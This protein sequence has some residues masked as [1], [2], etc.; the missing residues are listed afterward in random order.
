M[1]LALQTQG[2]SRRFPGGQ[3]VHALDLAVPA[4]A[5]YGFL[6]PNGAG[7]TTTIRLLLG[8][9]RAD[10][11]EIRL[12]GEPLD[13]LRRGVLARVGALVEN[14]SLYPHLDGRANLEVTRRLL[15]LPATRVGEVLER[16]GLAADAGRRVREYSLGMR[17]R[18]GIG[19][20]LLSRPRLLVLDEPGNG[21]DPAGTQ[22]LRGFLRELV[23]TEGLTLF[24]SSHLLGEIDQLASHVGVLD[25]GRLRFQGTLAALRERARHALLLRCDDPSR[26]VRVLVDA[27]EDPALAEGHALRLWPR[28]PVAEINRRLVAAGVA[29]THLAIEPVTLE[30]LFFE[31]TGPDPRREQV[32]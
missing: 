32:A 13:P 25:G 24:L 21:L 10:A 19:L 4:G 6:G 27:G 30:R 17:Q 22:Q 5:I 8:L 2:L 15:G 29:V 3:G 9:L 31:L 14:P 23:A 12:L 16:I 26:A 1:E 28:L 7:K 11:G 18:L 20:A